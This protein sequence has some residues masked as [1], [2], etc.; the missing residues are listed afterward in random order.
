MN[1]KP[2][3]H[4]FI[5]STQNT[6]NLRYLCGTELPEA[7]ML[8]QIGRTKKIIVSEMEY[9]RVRRFI[10]QDFSVFHPKQIGSS[11]KKGPRDWVKK[12]AS[13]NTLIVYPDFPI[14]LA[15]ILR[16]DGYQLIIS[17]DTIC[18]N[19]EIKTTKE[20][21]AIQQTQRA[22]VIAM[23]MAIQQISTA[24]IRR[25]KIL[26]SGN[27]KLTSEIVRATI[28]HTLLHLGC[29]AEKTIVSCGI[30]SA[31]PHERGEGPLHAEQP[32]VIDIF[33][34][35]ETT[36]YWGDI[37]RTLCRSFA[38]TALKKQYQAVKTAQ[39]SSLKAVKAG[40]R[41]S[42]IHQIGANIIKTRGY[43][44]GTIDGIPQ[45]FIHGTGH[46][47]GLEIHE[48]PIISS[49][50]H[51][52]LRIGHII[53]IEPGIYDSKIGGVR[54]EDTIVVTRDG[55]KMLAPCSKKLEI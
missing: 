49:T 32:I 43:K 38:P 42:T 24:R 51:K 28:G 5:S 3:T 55:Y 33:P 20:I 45:G 54:I 44:T 18:Q 7:T 52:K 40:V 21:K 11:W 36:G 29:I 48:K 8:I 10:K 30:A 26:Q 15:E 17:D 23:K 22:A 9:N 25:D 50:N 12:L 19:R 53:T 34:K 47:V 13:E 35:T 1:K 27:K 16:Q 6:A 46:G 2:S 39:A 31:D 14:G 37:T 41:A 4:L